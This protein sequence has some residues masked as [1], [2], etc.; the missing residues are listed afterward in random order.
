MDRGHHQDTR[1]ATYK[2]ADLDDCAAHD[3]VTRACDVGGGQP[4][5]PGGPPGMAGTAPL[6]AVSFKRKTVAADLFQ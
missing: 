1:L 4:R 5:P 3:L 6:G 2:L